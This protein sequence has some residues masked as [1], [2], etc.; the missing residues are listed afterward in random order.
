M[1]IK[2]EE[3]MIRIMGECDNLVQY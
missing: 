1:N 3:S 2:D